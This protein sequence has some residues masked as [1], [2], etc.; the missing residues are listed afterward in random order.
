MHNMEV[1][2]RVAYVL[3][4]RIHH[5]HCTGN[6]FYIYFFFFGGGGGGE[7]ENGHILV[8]VFSP[9]LTCWGTSLYSDSEITGHIDP[10]KVLPG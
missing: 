1:C 9:I 5:G 4:Q 7:D 6:I 3:N 8:H 2:L 10:V